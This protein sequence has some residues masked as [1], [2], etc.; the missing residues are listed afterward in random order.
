[1]YVIVVVNCC[2]KTPFSSEVDS[3]VDLDWDVSF[4]SPFV[5]VLGVFSPV[6]IED[7]VEGDVLKNFW[8]SNF[9]KKF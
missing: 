8:F 6:L 5:F 3:S 2:S 9:V 1:M 7:D 4:S